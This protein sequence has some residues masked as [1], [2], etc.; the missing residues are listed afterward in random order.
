MKPAN[1]GH[2]HGRGMNGRR[3]HAEDGDCGKN[4]SPH[5]VL[6]LVPLLSLL[7]SGKVRH[8]GIMKSCD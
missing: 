8:A 3:L 1:G 5:N 7:I 6:L 4:S 2:G